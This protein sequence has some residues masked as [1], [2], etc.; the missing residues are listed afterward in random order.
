VKTIQVRDDAMVILANEMSGDEVIAFLDKWKAAI[1]RGDHF[2]FADVIVLGELQEQKAE[3]TPEQIDQQFI[4]GVNR[5]SQTYWRDRMVADED[6]Q[7]GMKALFDRTGS[8]ATLTKVE[9]K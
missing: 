4:D 6:F 1:E 7:R 5:L 9:V 2:M 3:L 8:K